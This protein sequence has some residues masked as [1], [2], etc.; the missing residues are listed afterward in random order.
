MKKKILITGG[1]GFL[2]LHLAQRLKKNFNIILGSRNNKNNFLVEKKTNC[3]T[4]PLDITNINSV[5]DAINFCKPDIIIHAGATKF[6]GLSETQPFECADVNI[7]GSCNIARTAIDK[8]VKL[9]IGIS[10]DKATQPIQNFYGMS[11]AA[12]EKIFLLSNKLSKTKFLCVRYGNVAW[13]TGSVLPI[14]K[15]MFKKNKTI[16]TTGPYMRRFFFTADD[17]V[18]LVIAAL[19]NSKKI[20][21]KI[22]CPEMKSSKM[23]DILKVWVKKFGGKYKIINKRDGDRLDEYLIAENE[24][25]FTK[26][27]YHKKKKYYVIDFSKKIKNAIRQTVTSE[28][29][30]KLSEKEISQLLDLKY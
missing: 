6:V 28:N 8:G 1:N 18:D 13:S 5:R 12:M 4:F 16:L 22:L 19:E 27:F 15:E 9:V 10:T 20:A 17:A 2:G 3:K 7:M 26:N 30:Q 21:G 25:D 11:K 29:C 14:W 24:K 23:I